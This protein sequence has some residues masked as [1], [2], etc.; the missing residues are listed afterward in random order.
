MEH[1]HDFVG[2]VPERL[3]A[4]EIRRLSVLSPGRAMSA[5]AVE[6]LVLAGAILIATHFDRW[7]VSVPAIVL[8]GARQH[9]LLVLAH[10]ASHFRLLPGRKLNDWV[11]NL[12]LAWPTF[13]S[14]QG[15]R[16]FHGDH[17]RFLN[18]EGDGNRKL[19]KTHDALGQPTS[20]WRYPKSRSQLIT[21]LARRASGPT[22]VAWML[23]GMIGGFL[24]GVSPLA[25]VVRLSLW[26][27]L[28]GLLTHFGGWSAFLLYWIVPYCTWHVLA[29]YLRLV[30]EHSAIHADD[31]R[32][33]ETRTTIPGWLGR[34][35]ILPRNV[36][37]HLEHHWY[38]SVPFY[39]LPELHARLAELPGFRAHARCEQ[40]I[41]DSLRGCLR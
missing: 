30:C 24:F 33:A 40:S 32:Y 10:D 8:I 31:P 38:P 27:G 41:L 15:F 35:L 14:I 4:Q 5:I 26:A 36:G 34:L 7:W 37:H 12:L 25:H 11:G 13:V 6:W 20:E 29:Q 18:R 21:K 17:H 39:R 1:P 16:H 28:F 22:G 2:S 3:E 23:R 9:A 19:W